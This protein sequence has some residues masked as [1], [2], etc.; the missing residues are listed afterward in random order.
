MLIQRGI[1][2]LMEARTAIAIAHRLYTIQDVDRI[3]VIHKGRI[4]EFG[5]HEELLALEGVYHRLYR[6]QY[7]SEEAQAI[8]AG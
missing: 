2:N 7:R 6:L 8:A 5:T 3:Y 1:H 4:V